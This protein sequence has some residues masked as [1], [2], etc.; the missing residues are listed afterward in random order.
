MRSAAV[1]SPQPVLNGSGERFVDG[2]PS[3]VV[4]VVRPQVAVNVQCRLRARVTEAGLYDLDGR[5]GADQQRGVVVAEGVGRCP[6]RQAG[7]IARSTEHDRE[8]ARPSR[9]RT[10][11]SR[12]AA[13][14]AARSTPPRGTS[15]GSWTIPQDKTS[16][17]SEQSATRS[18]AASVNSS[19]NLWCRAE[20]P[21]AAGGNVGPHAV[22]PR[23][24]RRPH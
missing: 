11:S 7:T 21:A 17:T 1:G 3:P 12:W 19:P 18:T 13:A 16:N 5:A 4:V 8:R 23:H 22:S 24:A 14:T 20:R 9:R 10:L 15:T 2:P 6:C